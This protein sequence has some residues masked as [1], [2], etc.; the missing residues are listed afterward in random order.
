MIRL[1]GSNETNFITNGIGV[2]SDCVSCTVTEELNGMYELEME[3]PINGSR[4]GDIRL[5]RYI[6]AQPAVASPPEPF[7]IYKISRPI[8]GIISVYAQHYSYKTSS[9][10]IVPATPLYFSNKSPSSLFEEIVASA[11]EGYNDFTL[12]SDLGSADYELTEPKSLRSILGE[13]QEIYGGEF[14]W[15]KNT[16]YLNKHRGVDNG[17][18]IRYGKNMTDLKQEESIAN[19]IN[20]IAPYWSGREDDKPV[21]VT[22]P[23]KVAIYQVGNTAK[24]NLALRVIEGEFGDGEPRVIALNNYIAT[25]NAEHPDLD[26]DDDQSLLGESYDTI[27]SLVN[28]LCWQQTTLWMNTGNAYLRAVPYNMTQYFNEKPTVAKLTEKA[29]ILAQQLQIGVPEISLDVS[30]I[31]LSKT[32]E[33]PEGFGGLT[34]VSLGDTVHV[35]FE[36]LGVSGTAKVVK[37]VF[38]CIT[39]Q[40]DDIQLGDAR[41]NFVNTVAS[42]NTRIE[43]SESRTQAYFS[44]ALDDATSTIKGVHGGYVIIDEDGGHPSQIT[45]LNKPSKDDADKAIRINYE[46]IGFSNTGYYGSFNSA[47]DINGTFDA[48]KINVINLS[49]SRIKTDSLESQNYSTSG[50]TK[51]FSFDLDDGKI[52]AP[53][54]SLEIANT[55]Q[56]EAVA[57][58]AADSK[59]NDLKSAFIFASNGLITKATINGSESPYNTRVGS[60]GF[61]IE[62]GTTTLGKFTNGGLET[63]FV[64]IG[65]SDNPGELLIPPLAIKPYDTENDGVVDSW[66]IVKAN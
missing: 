40:Y 50:Q 22:I 47:W 30:F 18:T 41:A 51:G 15:S 24:Q 29:V 14:R 48:S 43:E 19:T 59:L 66:I 2:L 25:Y 55:A 64:T 4:Y 12:E 9:I 44:N 54:L 34:T 32:G 21:L 49:A 63:G 11:P 8:G 26:P 1:Y 5:G 62:E 17:V 39:G 28:K 3:Y 53:E 65:K 7:E 13:M 45:I 23:E 60:D 38:N 10:P 52:Y 31:S 27:Q 58:I 61:Y 37:T 56:S 35:Y 33:Y 16:I 6:Y 20:G 36:K 57:A 42:V 46:G